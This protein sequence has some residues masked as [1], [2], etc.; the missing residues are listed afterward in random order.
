MREEGGEV[1]GEEGEEEEGEV[2]LE[3][4]EGLQGGGRSVQ[5]GLLRGREAWR[6][7]VEPLVLCERVVLVK[8]LRLDGALRERL[9]EVDAGYF[10][11]WLEDDA[12]DQGAC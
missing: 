7:V 11:D 8:F 2:R 4:E 5:G 6:G 12:R 3:E 10:F 9:G 1:R